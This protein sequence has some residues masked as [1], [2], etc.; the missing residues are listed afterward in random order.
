MIEIRQSANCTTTGTLGFNVFEKNLQ[1]NKS[2]FLL[3]AVARKFKKKFPKFTRKQMCQSF[4][5]NKVAG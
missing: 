4:L 1:D 5:F 3:E 2:F